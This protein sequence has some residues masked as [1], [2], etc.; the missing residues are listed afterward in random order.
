MNKIVEWS[1]TW[2]D[3]RGNA[4]PVQRIQVELEFQPTFS[5]WLEDTSTPPRITIAK[6]RHEVSLWAFLED[7]D[8]EGTLHPTILPGVLQDTLLHRCLG[9][10]S[11]GKHYLFG[12]SP[13]TNFLVIEARSWGPVTSGWYTDYVVE[14]LPALVTSENLCVT[15]GLGGAGGLLSILS[16][17]L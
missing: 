5:L 6:L 1:E 7:P 11:E 14:L 4:I 12:S 2:T 15:A 16:P 3:P 10:V 8:S 9:K 13:A 17:V